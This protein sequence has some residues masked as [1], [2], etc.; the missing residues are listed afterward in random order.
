MSSR[1]PALIAWSSAGVGIVLVSS[2][3]VLAATSGSGSLVFFGLVVPLVLSTSVVGGLV[4]SRHPANPIGWIFCGF[5]VFRAASALAAGS[6]DVAPNDARSG[7]GQ[8]AAWFFNW[9]FVS[10]FALLIFVLLLFPDGRLPGRRWG[11]ALWCAGAGTI[12]VAVG[13]ALS[14]GRLDDFATVKNPFGID[15]DVALGLLL[16]GAVASTVALVAAVASVIAR[17][18][19]AGPVEKQQIKWLAVASVFTA[20]CVVVGITAALIGASI[21]GYALILSSILAIPL[22]I[23]VAM[24]R[25]RLY[26]I[27]RLISRSLTYLLVTA[28]LGAAY[29]GLVLGGQAL[30]SAFTGGSDLAIAISTLVVAAL[31]LPLRAR[32]QGLVDRRFNRRRYDMART[33]EAFNARL[34]HEVELDELR[35]D[36]EDVVAATM[37]PSHVSIWLSEAHG[38]RGRRPWALNSGG[39]NGERPRPT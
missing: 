2:G 36:L 29:A 15:E 23:G 4:A 5:S 20:L 33:L 32:V 9:S 27:D 8:L 21:A 19:H 37:Q 35:A 14:P 24:L 3:A 38:P 25:Y 17:Y 13:T 1:Q 39:A 12:L 31:F 11:A 22:A 34:R 28:A 30:F 7:L 6:A 16:A 26:D 10:L 18:R